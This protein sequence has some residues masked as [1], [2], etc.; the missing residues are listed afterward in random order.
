MGDKQMGEMT[1]WEKA[2]LKPSDFSP[3]GLKLTEGLF[4]LGI[5]VPMLLLVYGLV[6]YWLGP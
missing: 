1:E 2:Q 4:V 3:F 5:T 6:S